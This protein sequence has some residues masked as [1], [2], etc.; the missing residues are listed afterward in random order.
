MG[1]KVWTW[2]ALLLT[3]ASFI[4]GVAAQGAAP[5]DWYACRHR[6]PHRLIGQLSLSD[7]Y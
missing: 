2:A 4:L 1:M 5:W 3:L 7:I 6:P